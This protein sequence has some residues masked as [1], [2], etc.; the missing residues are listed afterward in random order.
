MYEYIYILYLFPFYVFCNT[1][2][3]HLFNYTALMGSF[4][5]L[6]FLAPWP[7]PLSVVETANFLS[8]VLSRKK[9]MLQHPQEHTPAV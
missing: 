5:R 3:F 8:V 2:R 4:P 7:C 6:S 1:L 9:Q